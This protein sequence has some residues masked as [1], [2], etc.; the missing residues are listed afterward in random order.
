MF[1]FNPIIMI[2]LCVFS[3]VGCAEP[4]SLEVPPMQDAG[5]VRMPFDRIPEWG[6]MKSATEWNREWSD[7][8]RGELVPVPSYDIRQLTVPMSKAT[9]DRD[10]YRDIIT[11]KLFYSARHMGALG[12][13]DADE[14]SGKHEGVDLYMPEGTPA[15]AIADGEIHA[16]YS[17]GNLGNGAALLFEADG[18]QWMAVYGHCQKLTVEQGQK[19]RRG[20]NVCFVGHT[21]KATAPHLHLQIDVVN[22]LEKWKVYVPTEA[23][24]LEADEFSVNPIPFILSH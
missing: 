20:Q 1:H 19:V 8:R 15:M 23:I 6:A 9:K 3:L 14:Y 11:A 4:V 17:T 24:G 22:D 12:D 2:P 18:K 16:T 7:Y 13:L 21:G 10:A 5:A